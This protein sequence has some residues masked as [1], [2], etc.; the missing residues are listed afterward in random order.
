MKITELIEAL[1]EIKKEDGDLVVKFPVI[2]GKIDG[3][4]ELT[5]DNLNSLGE[6]VY[7]ALSI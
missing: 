5:K 2:W 6:G 7:L 3:Y 4:D 1:E